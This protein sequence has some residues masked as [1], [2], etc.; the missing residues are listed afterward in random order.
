MS[1]SPQEEEIS[2]NMCL[3]IFLAVMKT[4]HV[5]TLAYQIKISPHRLPTCSQLIKSYSS[6]TDVDDTM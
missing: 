3:Q 1:R 6:P 4:S 2:W 5:L